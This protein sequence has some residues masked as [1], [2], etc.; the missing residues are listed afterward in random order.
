MHGYGGPEV[1][2]YEECEPPRPGPGQLVV[3]VEAAGVNPIDWQIRSG[4]DSART[5]RQLPA[6]LGVDFAG[7]VF[8]VGAGVLRF[9]VGDRVFGQ[10]EPAEDGSYAE[11]VRVNS[12]RVARYP[13]SLGPVRAA[14][15]PTMSL[16]AWHGLFE[17]GKLQAGTRVLIAGVAGNVGRLAAQLCRRVPGVTVTGI[18][19]RPAWT[20]ELRRICPTLIEPV[21]LAA[22]AGP[23]GSFDLVLNFLGTGF[24]SIAIRATRHGGRMITT[25]PIP[26]FERAGAHGVLAISLGRRFVREHLETVAH[27]VARGEMSLPPLHVEHLS[28]AAWVHA[29][30][31]SRHLNGKA[32]LVPQAQPG[33]QKSPSTGSH[34][35]SA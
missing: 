18:C 34:A 29:M 31:E 25:S 13:A 20:E 26:D 12:A 2:R 19:R 7:R 8:S 4:L 23:R 10:C 14:S 27:L 6:V 1:L 35:E 22:V 21:N 3:S 16:A 30:A 32:V 33:F 17:F 11:F 28:S 24:E 5:S 9:Q 15:L